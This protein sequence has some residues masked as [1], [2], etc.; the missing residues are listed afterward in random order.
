ML[1]SEA[2]L[3]MPRLR[4]EAEPVL[5]PL[6]TAITFVAS[7]ALPV[8]KRE[9]V[10]A[11]H[12]RGRVLAASIVAPQA[13]PP[14]DNSAMDGYALAG[15]LHSAAAYRLVGRAAA[16]E[17][18]PAALQPGEAIRILTGAAVP[19]GTTAVLKQ[20]DAEIGPST[21]RC[22]RAP[23]EGANIRR[24]GE[25]VGPGEAVIQ[26]GTRLDARHIALISALGIASVRVR[27][28]VR[29]A[30][31]STGS[32]LTAPGEALAEGAMF[33]SNRA[34]ILACLD[35]ADIATSD[36]GIVPDHPLALADLL[37]T[38]SEG[39]DLVISSGGVSA[40]EE[41]HLRAA[42]LRAGGSFEKLHVALK[43]G[44]PLGFGRIGRAFLL[45]LPGN[46]VAALAAL[47]LVGRPLLARLAGLAPQPAN[48]R[49][50]IVGF[51][52]KADPARTEFLP[53]R[54]TGE[55]AVGRTVVEPAGPS[56]AARLRPLI[57]ADGFCVLPPSTEPIV[58]GDRLAFLG[59]A[60][61]EIA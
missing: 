58:P 13:L 8:S 44:K 5:M 21:V 48:F 24:A 41:D 40:S 20:E 32:E 43:P 2:T 37:F 47:L 14:F 25:D 28:R 52:R 3:L 12:S 30:V 59:L 54:I 17:P 61:S 11:A 55:D 36:R 23:A 7:A 9:D 26:A 38:A 29:V 39:A 19:H 31:I 15:R 42:A 6:D 4:N 45:G 16:G 57:D 49:T 34:M 1:L 35:R 51:S 18:F 60:D 56:G 53:V 50:A 33:D 46:P 22:R 10:D 27:R